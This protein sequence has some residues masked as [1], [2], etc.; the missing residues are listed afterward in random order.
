VQQI[1]AFSRQSNPQ[2]QPV[3]LPILVQ[4]SLSLV[5][6]TMPTTIALESHLDPDAGG[7]LA[8]PTNLQQILMNLCT[9]AEYAMRQP[10]GTLVVSLTRIEVEAN[11]TANPAG[12]QPG[13]YVRLT[14]RDTGDGIPPETVGRIF[15]PFF[16]TK[17]VG[18]GTGMGLA[19]VHGIV[20]SYGG[21]VTVESTPGEGSAF[22]V[23]L[24]RLG[25]SVEADPSE[26]P[27]AGPQGHGCIL[28]VDDEELLARLGQETLEPL[29]YEVVPSVSSVDALSLFQAAPQRFDLVITDQTMPVMTGEQLARELRRIRIDIPII[30]CTGFSHL[31][32]AERAQA[33]GISAFCM[34]P[35]DIQELARTIERVLGR[36]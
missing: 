4:E 7:V 15:E 12:L 32:D 34:K 5:R 35:V 36:H 2:R 23:D 29:G 25:E 31:I 3:A 9:N 30:L 21:A 8:D 14:V 13:S 10:G 33:V 19:I 26:S 22:R 27:E 6:A 17:G 18:E 28:F 11:A 24:P 16:T 1:L 20:T